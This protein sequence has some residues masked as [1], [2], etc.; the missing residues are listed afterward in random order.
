MKLGSLFSGYGGLDLGVQ[1][2]LGTM[3]TAWVSDIEPGPSTIL[4]SRFP[5][6][7]NLG[8]ITQIDWTSVEP[9]DVIAGGS[10][11]TDLSL[12]GA[13]AGM[14]PGTRSE[15]WES[16]FTALWLW[17]FSAIRTVATLIISTETLRTT[18]SQI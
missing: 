8:D 10:P 2:A 11:C 12:A 1:A 16:I 4:T 7:P 5:D 18:N 17:H 14:K 9:V 15:L 13:R 6:S 3:E